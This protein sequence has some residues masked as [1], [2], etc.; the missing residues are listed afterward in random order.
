MYNRR[1]DRKNIM[2]KNDNTGGVFGSAVLE[3]KNNSGKINFNGKIDPNNHV[4]I[5]GYE[6]GSNLWWDIGKIGEATFNANNVDGKGHPIEF[7]DVVVMGKE[8]GNGNFPTSVNVG[9]T[10]GQ[11]NWR[12]N[13]E[14]IYNTSKPAL[15]VA[16]DEKNNVSVKKNVFEETNFDDDHEAIKEEVVPIEE[17]TIA[18][19]EKKDEQ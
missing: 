6:S 18:V 5:V 17:E 19:E 11:R 13:I 1:Y 16:K 15:N 7:F 8:D 10:N 4:Y 3:I 2:L 12:K 9:F 14:K